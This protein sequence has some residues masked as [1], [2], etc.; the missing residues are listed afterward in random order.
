MSIEFAIS[1]AYRINSEVSISQRSNNVLSLRFS[2][3]DEAIM[4]TREL[5]IH[6]DIFRVMRN[7]SE[8]IVTII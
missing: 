2:N 4:F 8:V 5:S 7:D 3:E 1:V 6:I